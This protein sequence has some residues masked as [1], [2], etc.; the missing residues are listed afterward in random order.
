M[1]LTSQL[2]V[3]TRDEWRTWLAAHHE[4]EREV[5]LIYCRKHS[6]KPRIPYD[7]A[8]EEALC[9]GW[10]DSIV[11]R[12]DDE[13]FAQKFTPRKNTKR[14]SP[15]NL[16]RVRR[17]IRNGLMTDAGLEKID[18]S[19]TRQPPPARADEDENEVPEFVE[20]A[21][22]ANARAWKN[23]NGLAPSYRRQYVGWIA[24]AK[25]EQTRV[26]R[27]SEAIELLER[28]QKLGMK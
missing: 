4:T 2:Y 3:T 11:Q 27:L 19:V 23:F 9:F 18:P 8:V 14:W 21:F 15:S 24:S 1:K 25:R 17:L 10:I 22:R 5:W 6:G 20:R 7:D 13:R 16:E 12:I 26:K 28:N